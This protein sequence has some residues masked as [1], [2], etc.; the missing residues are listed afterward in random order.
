MF[1]NQR[2]EIMATTHQ[3][4]ELPTRCLPLRAVCHVQPIAGAHQ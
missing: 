4:Q 1:S 3:N 2:H